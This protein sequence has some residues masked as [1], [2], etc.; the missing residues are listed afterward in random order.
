MWS[1]L[2]KIII[3]KRNQNPDAI[4]HVS[5]KL[6]LIRDYRLSIGLNF[7]NCA[8]KFA[9]TSRFSHWSVSCTKT[10]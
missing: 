10:E 5:N 1:Y 2:I 8:P 9:T 6:L 3:V 7:R 4:F